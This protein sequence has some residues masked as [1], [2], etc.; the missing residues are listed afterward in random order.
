MNMVI[1]GGFETRPYSQM[2]RGGYG[3]DADEC[4]LLF[5]EDKTAALGAGE[6]D[7]LSGDRCRRSLGV[8][9]CLA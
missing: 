2:V 4:W 1:R 7:H 8:G 5:R 9:E 3:L 6:A